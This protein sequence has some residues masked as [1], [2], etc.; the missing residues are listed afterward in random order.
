MRRI[1]ILC[2]AGCCSCRSRQADGRRNRRGNS[3]QSGTS[4]LANG[5]GGRGDGHGRGGRPV[6]PDGHPER[7]E[8]EFRHLQASDEVRNLAQVKVGDTV[9]FAITNPSRCAC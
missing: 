1:V 3:R 4:V 6:D 9:K 2:S 8:G 5:H 7:T